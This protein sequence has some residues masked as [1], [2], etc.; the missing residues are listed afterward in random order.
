MGSE[1][2]ASLSWRANL[3]SICAPLLLHFAIC[4][5]AF[6]ATCPNPNTAFAIG[7][8]AIQE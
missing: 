7:K 5:S 1:L 3:G 8:M 2:L 6:P 4:D